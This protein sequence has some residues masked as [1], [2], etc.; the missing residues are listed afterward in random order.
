M[1]RTKSM[2]EQLVKHLHGGEAFMPVEKM[3]EEIEFS[4][5]GER[6][7]DLPYSFYELF[8]HIW[9][10]QKDILN[11]CTRINYKAPE[12]P[13]DYWPGDEKPANEKDWTILK[14]AYLKERQQL[15]ALVLNP[16]NDL[17]DSVPSNTEHSLL[18]EILLVIEHNAYHSGQLLIILRH[19]GLHTT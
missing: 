19:V 17:T 5:L 8:Y 15:S 3:L 10:T 11:Y 12:W 2:K 1:D 16:E 6:P 7:S 14:E 9:F 13:T 4:K 18:R